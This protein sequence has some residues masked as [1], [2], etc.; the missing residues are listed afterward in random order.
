[1]YSSL[2]CNREALQAYWGF[3]SEKEALEN[4]YSF[5]SA[6]CGYNSPEAF[7]E[8]FAKGE[9]ILKGRLIYDE[10]KVKIDMQRVKD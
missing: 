5:I 4:A 8:I 3:K 6:F 9:T 7:L 1:M 10:G 2:I